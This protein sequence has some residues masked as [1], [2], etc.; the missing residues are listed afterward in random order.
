MVGLEVGVAGIDV[1]P[2]GEDELTI[3]VAHLLFR[4]NAPLL[5]QAGHQVSG[6]GLLLGGFV[7]SGLRS[8]NGLL[9]LL[10]G[11]EFEAVFVGAVDGGDLVLVADHLAQ[12]G[13]DFGEGDAF[14]QTLDELQLLFGRKHRFAVG[15]VMQALAHI[16][17]VAL[18][19]AFGVVVLHATEELQLGAVHFALGETMLAGALH[20]RCQC[21]DA[22]QHV[23]LLTTGKT[24]R[25]IFGGG[26][27]E[28]PVTQGSRDEGGVGL[29]GEFLQAVVH[30]LPH[31]VGEVAVTI[32]GFGV[33]LLPRC[34]LALHV[35]GEEGDGLFGVLL[36]K[37]NH[38][39]VVRNGIVD[40]LGRVGRHRDGRE[41][42]LNLLF[43]AIDIDV[44]HHDDGLQVGAIPLLVVVTQILVGK[45]VDHVHRTN[46][47]AVLVLRAT[48]DDGLCL[49]HEPLHGHARAA[50]AP[51]LVDDA[52]L[53]VDF[54][55]AEQKR[56]APVVEDEQAGVGHAGLVDRSGGDVVD[57][58][59]DTG[60]GV[61]VGTELDALAL[62]PL[63]QAAL[64][65]TGE[66]LGAVEG[67]VFEK[68]G[69]SS[70]TRLFE[71]GAH[72]L[73]NV[74]VGHVGRLAV[75]PDVIGQSVGEASG[76]D[77]GVVWQLCRGV[78]CGRCDGQS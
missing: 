36:L 39:L 47:Q 66:V 61:E 65:S 16:L 35:E 14:V 70:L 64:L 42:V 67:H 26:E 45:V 31:D 15:E 58:L 63:P 9:D 30:H 46:G 76:P 59:V 71:D 1:H 37:E 62:A 52:A 57:R 25:G 49:F 2:V 78:E 43:D 34:G 51:L 17:S 27:E 54:L 32:V 33:A 72:A 41:E 56:V 3:A 19:M 29:F 38:P 12:H 75:L 69:K 4:D 10:V 21:R 53:L 5:G 77:G 22:A 18:L 48:I 24:A 20:G 73:S 11:G 68:V 50:G 40:A 60:V 74:E 28:L 44:A 13:V 8:E 7:L 6:Y 23:L 55:V